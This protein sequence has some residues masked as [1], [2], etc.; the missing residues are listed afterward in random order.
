MGRERPTWQSFGGRPVA[1][2]SHRRV[3]LTDVRGSVRRASRCPHTRLSRDRGGAVRTVPGD[4]STRRLATTLRAVTM[5]VVRGPGAVDV[6]NVAVTALLP[7]RLHRRVP[8]T[9]VR[10]SVW[11]GPAGDPT[12]LSRDRE[13]A[14][15]TVPG[16]GSTRRLAT[17]LRAVTMCVVYGPGVADVA[18]FR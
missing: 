11:A 8:L 5:C 13:G 3:P 15:R 14:V 12:R 1:V 9:D 16:G 2:R 17:T 4:G 6:A 7:V 10:G 18:R